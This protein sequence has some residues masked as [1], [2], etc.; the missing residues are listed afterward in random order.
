MAFDMSSYPNS[1]WHDQLPDRPPRSSLDGQSIETDVVIVGAGFTGLWTA[2]HLSLLAPDLQV[3]L[4]EA[5]RVGF[6]ASGRNGGWCIAELAADRARWTKLSSE[7]GA[8]ALDLAMHETVDT[9]EGVVADHGIDCDFARGGEL[10]LARNGGQVA[11]LKALANGSSSVWLD[12]EA[13]REK[14]GATDVRG[15]LFIAATAVLQPAKLATSLADIVEAAGVHVYEQTRAVAVEPGIVMTKH[16]EIKAKHVVLATEGYTAAIDGYRRSLAPL[17]SMMVATEPLSDD[18]LAEVRLDD[19]PTFADGRFHVIYGQRTADNRLAFGGRC[20]PYQFG[21]KIPPDEY[22]Q[23]F[24][25]VTKSL[26]ELFPSVADA[27]VTHQWGGVMGLPRNWTPSVNLDTEQRFYRAGGY[28]GEGV[29]ATALAGRTMALA[30]A[31]VDD[32]ALRLPWV[33]ASARRWP[34]EPFRWAGIIAGG[35]IFGLADR[36]ENRIDK[37][38]GWATKISK[39]LRR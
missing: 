22:Y 5:E 17:S 30:I 37:P 24:D 4:I 20:V 39:V 13:A 16:G 1:L 7:A 19:R 36:L 10:H 12:D 3:T 9:I 6:G 32:P 27:K 35:H 14:C 21:S 38:A 33:R 28:V 25:A 34:I 11:R 2:Y 29:A 15:G 23:N 31:G 26:V 8:A 18:M